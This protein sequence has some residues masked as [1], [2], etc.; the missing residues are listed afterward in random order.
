MDGKKKR[1]E[2]K[3]IVPS[4][5]TGRRLKIIALGRINAIIFDCFYKDL[6][7]SLKDS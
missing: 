5:K 2:G 6:Q 7:G 4:S 3:R 1:K